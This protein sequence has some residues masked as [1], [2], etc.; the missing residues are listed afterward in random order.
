MM[1]SLIASWTWRY[2]GRRSSVLNDSL[3][4]TSPLTGELAGHDLP[5]DV[6]F[7][8]CASGL[9]AIG[10]ESYCRIVGECSA[11]LTMGEVLWRR[12]CT[13]RVT[14]WRRS[15][16]SWRRTASTVATSFGWLGRSDRAVGA[17]LLLSSGAA[18]CRPRQHPA[19]RR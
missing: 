12:T 16:E 13:C 10:S 5:G 2:K 9:T 18:G 11:P 6:R 8:P 15:A 19:A 1:Y 17:P 14:S 3:S 4:W 7:S